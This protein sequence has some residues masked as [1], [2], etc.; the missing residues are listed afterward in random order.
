MRDA[1]ARVQLSARPPVV[2]LV[3]AALPY[4]GNWPEADEQKPSINVRLAGQSGRHVSV[5]ER[6]LMTQPV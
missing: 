1:G 4:V 3:A 6:L 2:D 5:T